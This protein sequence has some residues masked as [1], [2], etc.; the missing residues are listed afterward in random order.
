MSA[1][2]FGDGTFSRG[3]SVSFHATIVLCD[4]ATRG[5]RMIERAVRTHASE[6][7][8]QTSAWRC[9]S[10]PRAMGRKCGRQ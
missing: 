1:E 5:E 7:G 6:R 8:R 10:R 3:K 2:G 9:Q 4:A